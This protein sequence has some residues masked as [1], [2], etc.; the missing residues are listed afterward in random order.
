MFFKL[1]VLVAK[2]STIYNECCIILQHLEYRKEY[3]ADTILHSWTPPEVLHK[4]HARG[5]FGEDRDGHPV[6]YEIPGNY[7]MRGM[8]VAMLKV[9]TPRRVHY[10][11]YNNR[12]PSVFNKGGHFEV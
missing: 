3:G 10:V 4:F 11:Q 6:F 7:D 5:I 9:L 8:Y 12:F 1:K 2:Q